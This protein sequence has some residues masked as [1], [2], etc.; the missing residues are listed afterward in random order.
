MVD[1]IKFANPVGVSK[2]SGSG[3]V[4]SKIGKEDTTIA[5]VVLFAEA[6]PYINLKL[7]RK[8]TIEELHGIISE[9]ADL[10]KALK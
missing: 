3:V 8:V 7:N 4:T 6:T 5:G 9:L 2:I 1:I 10:E